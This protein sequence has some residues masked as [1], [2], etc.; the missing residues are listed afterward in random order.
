VFRTNLEGI[1]KVGTYLTYL[2]YLTYLPIFFKTP[3]TAYMLLSATPAAGI[4]AGV[5]ESLL[6]TLNNIYHLSGP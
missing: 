2:A 5:E 6:R 4:I 3:G 1:G